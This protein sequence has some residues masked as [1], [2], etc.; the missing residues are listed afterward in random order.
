ME[1]KSGGIQSMI[2]VGG[3]RG[4]G[5]P[6]AWS[7]LASARS[8]DGELQ[9]SA[10]DR[11]RLPPGGGGPRRRVGAPARGAAD[12]ATVGEGEERRGKGFGGSFE[13]LFRRV[14]VEWWTS[15]G[16]EG[17]KRAAA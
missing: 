4:A 9:N 12:L 3:R 6:R 2:V 1:L 16:G 11:R 13:K 8:G 7:A 15:V 14:V 5:G 10:P 17:A